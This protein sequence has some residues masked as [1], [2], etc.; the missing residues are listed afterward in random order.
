MADTKN[1]EDNYQKILAQAQAQLRSFKSFVQ[2][3]GAD[4]VIGA[5]ALGN[6]SDGAYYSQRDE[7]WANRTIGYSSENILSVGCLVS[8]V[9]M[10]AK[11]YGDNVTPG[12][13]ASDVSRFYGNTA[14]MSRPWKGVAGKSFYEAVDINQELQNGNYIIVGVGNCNNGGSHFVVITKKDGEDYIMH[15]PIYGPDLKFSSHYSNICSS[16]TFK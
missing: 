13:I 8:S 2:S 7:R 11:H 1:D 16:A 5:N 4:S 12:D 10:V 15:D 14:Y 3:S 9:S 6:G